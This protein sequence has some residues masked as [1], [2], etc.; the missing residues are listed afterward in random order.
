MDFQEFKDFVDAVRYEESQSVNPPDPTFMDIFS[1]ERA[2]QALCKKADDSNALNEVKFSDFKKSRGDYMAGFFIN[3]NMY[4]LNAYR[5]SSEEPVKAIIT[6]VRFQVNHEIYYFRNS[7]LSPLESAKR[8][9][10]ISVRVMRAFGAKDKDEWKY[11]LIENV[12]SFFEG[13]SSL[14]SILAKAEMTL[15]YALRS[16][17]WN[18]ITV[19]K[20]DGQ[21]FNIIF[22]EMSKTVDIECVVP[23]PTTH[24][25]NYVESQKFVYERHGIVLAANADTYFDVRKKQLLGAGTERSQTS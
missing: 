5:Q 2:M 12:N 9:V 8:V 3:G 14:D 24:I 18:Q 16:H 7:R 6:P 21:L 15:V 25:V 1:V 11:L 19:Q 4:V 22:R 13:S 10:S 17:R 23:V 20:S